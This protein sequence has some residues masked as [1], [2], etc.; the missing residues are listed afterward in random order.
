MYISTEEKMKSIKKEKIACE[1][2][3]LL[4]NRRHFVSKTVKKLTPKIILI[5]LM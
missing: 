5:L 2:V 1:I 4:K 3:I